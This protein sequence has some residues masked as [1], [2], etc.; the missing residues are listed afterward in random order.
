LSLVCDPDVDAVRLIFEFLSRSTL[1]LL[2]TLYVNIDVNLSDPD[3]RRHDPDEA[4]RN[5]EALKMLLTLPHRVARQLEKVT[6]KVPQTHD[7]SRI[8]T[9]FDEVKSSGVLFTV[10][11]TLPTKNSVIDTF[12]QERYKSPGKGGR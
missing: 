3:S 10:C 11:D 12:A 2:R 1:P 7:L 4:E 8:C 6:V 5:A 9:L